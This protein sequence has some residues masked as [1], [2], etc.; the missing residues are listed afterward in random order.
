[1]MRN[2]LNADSLVS[3]FGTGSTEVGIFFAIDFPPVRAPG[4]TNRP[5][6]M[7]QS[8]QSKTFILYEWLRVRPAK[9]FRKCYQV[10]R[11]RSSPFDVQVKPGRLIRQFHTP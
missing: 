8:L 7:P 2:N 9:Y 10:C 6:Q 3:L 4:T 11:F 1:M 5:S